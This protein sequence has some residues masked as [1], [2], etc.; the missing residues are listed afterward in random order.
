MP[1]ILTVSPRSLAA[2]GVEVT[3]RATGE[4]STRPIEEVEAM[5]SELEPLVTSWA[6]RRMAGGCTG[7]RSVGGAATPIAPPDDLY[8]RLEVATDA[9]PRHR[10]RLAVAAPSP[11]PRRCRPPGSRAREAHQR[12]PRLAQRSRPSRP[13]RPRARDPRSRARVRRSSGRRAAWR[14]P[15]AGHARS[16]VGWRRCADHGSGKAGVRVASASRRSRG[17]TGRVPIA[18]RQA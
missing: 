2:G 14:G 13:I 5:L 3:E 1:W 12:R 8:A 4:R 10:G 7:G 6:P 11:P 15:C 9:V 17:G 16:R 18:G